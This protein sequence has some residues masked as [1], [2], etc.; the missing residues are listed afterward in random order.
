MKIKELKDLIKNLPDDMEVV[1]C[2]FDHS[3]CRIL[4]AGKVNAEGRFK[5]KDG[6]YDDYSEYYG[7]KYL[8]DES[9][10]TEVFLI[11]E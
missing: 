11:G 4:R 10:K 8:S 2:G 7:K 5:R 3:Y 9:E 6:S 1:K